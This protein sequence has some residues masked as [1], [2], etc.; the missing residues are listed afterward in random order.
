MGGFDLAELRLVEALRRWAPELDVRVEVVGGPRVRAYTKLIRGRW[1]PGTQ[2]APIARPGRVDLRHVTGLDVRPPAAT[3][4]V[5][6]IHDLAP[7]RFPDEGT[8]PAHAHTLV[9]NAARILVP[10]EFTRR[11]VHELFGVRLETITVVP[12]GI[13]NQA[14]GRVEA[15]DAPALARLGIRKPYVVRI[16]GY[17]QRKNVRRLLDCWPQVRSTTRAQ[18]VLAG[19]DGPRRADA[20]AAAGSLDGVL[21]LGYVAPNQILPLIAGASALVSPSVYEGF[22]FPP[23]EAMTV[24]TPT[25]A[26]RAGATS[27]VCGDAALLVDDDTAALAHGLIRVIQDDDLRQA[28]VAAGADRLAGFSWKRHARALTDV[29]LRLLNS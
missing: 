8:L 16:G 17:T 20:V 9:A 13:G 1:V 3:P 18:L 5:V 21:V 10:S 23:L 19:P 27:E 6:M 28:L 22:G 12:Q 24:G 11:E 14:T 25:V 29:Y 4:Y 7:L 15:L 2:G 26:V